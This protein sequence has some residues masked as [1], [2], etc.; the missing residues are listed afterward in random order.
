MAT[1][2]R[3]GYVYAKQLVGPQP[4]SPAQAL[5]WQ[6]DPAHRTRTINVYLSDGT[7]VIGTFTIGR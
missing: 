3:E 6:R 2:G 5:E 4:T 1:N 7:T